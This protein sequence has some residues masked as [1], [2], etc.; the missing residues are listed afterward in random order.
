MPVPD[1]AITEIVATLNKDITL[2]SVNTALKEAS[3]NELK[4]I[5]EFT[6]DDIVSSD[7]INNRHSSII[8]GQ[9]TSV[10][11]NRMVK[12]LTW[13]DNEYGYSQRL[14]EVADYM[15]SKL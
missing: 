6:M 11:G 4:G 14:L 8:D 10:L 5:L 2:E 15:A 9:S 1:G 12:I 13:Y 3:E 7:I